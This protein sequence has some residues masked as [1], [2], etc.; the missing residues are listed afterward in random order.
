MK[1][2]NGHEV[3]G[4]VKFCPTCG[5]D[6]RGTRFCTN[7]GY[8]RNGDEEVCPHCG[9]TFNTHDTY[10]YDTDKTESNRSL[11]IILSVVAIVIIGV[12]CWLYNKG[13]SPITATATTKSK[14]TEQ[15]QVVDSIGADTIAESSE[16][17]YSESSSY[18]REYS[19]DIEQ[20]DISPI[21][22][23]CQNEITAIQREIEDVCRTFVVLGSQDV[24]MYKYTQ[25][26][27]TFLNGVSD[28]QR[29]A[30]KA[31]DKCARE[32]QE[33]G[34]S[35]AVAKVNE[36]KRQFHSAIYELTTRATQQTDMSY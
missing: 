14:K 8:E 4:Q 19:N 24:D 18:D 2:P 36:E 13:N 20:V 11:L 16:P 23:E 12:G 21:L 34:Y 15:I 33:A 10:I 5:A 28:L 7:C 22:Y 27:S 32:L 31:F 6:L 17:Y 25:M 1:C 30:D 9:T 3:N 35:D 26:K 29:K